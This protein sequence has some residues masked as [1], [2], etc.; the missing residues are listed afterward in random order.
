MKHPKV[1]V[2]IKILDERARAFIPKYHSDL[3]SGFDLHCLDF[4]QLNPGETMLIKTG[5]AI[6]VPPG[7]E[8]Q[9]RPRSGLSLKTNFRVANSPGTVDADYLGDIS[10]IGVNVGSGNGF[11]IPAPI[12]FHP[13]DRIAQAVVVPIVQAEFTVVD[14]LTPTSRGTS[15]FGSTGST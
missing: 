8:L 14:D 1:P 5:L 13:G 4:C 6:Q 3:A 12:T 7:Y 11:F 10:V 2:K 15:G 9:V